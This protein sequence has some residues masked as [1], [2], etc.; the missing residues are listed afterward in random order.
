MTKPNSRHATSRQPF[1]SICVAF[2]RVSTLTIIAASGSDSRPGQPDAA[3][4]DEPEG[5]ARQGLRIGR[6][7]CE[8]EKADE[9]RDR[10]RSE[11]PQARKQLREV[12]PAR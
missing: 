6:G 7:P 12:E 10:H 5:E 9:L 1:S 11:V 4:R 8:H 2:T 3:H